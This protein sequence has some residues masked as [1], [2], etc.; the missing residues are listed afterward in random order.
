[1]KKGVFTVI[2]ICLCTLLA[3]QMPNT[4]NYQAVARNSSGQALA[5][6]AIKIR[7]SIIRGA[8]T[9][10]SETRNVTTNTLGLFNVQIG[11]SGATS[12]T[13]DFN[14]I[15]W[16]NNTP[17]ITLKVEL[18][19]N[20]SG[21]F[22]E[23]GNQTLASVPYAYAA[24]KAIDAVNLGGRYVDDAIA[25]N[26]GD[27]MRWS[28]ADNAWK[29]ATVTQPAV[30]TLQGII[31]SIA[32]SAQWVFLTT[33]GNNNLT[34]TITKPTTVVISGTATLG[35]NTT[36]QVANDVS[37]MPAFQ[38]I[39]NGVP[40]GTVTLFNPGNFPAAHIT[41]SKIVVPTATS[42]TIATPGT[43]RIGFAVRNNTTITLNNND[44]LSGYVMV[45]Q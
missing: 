40:A 3:A 45:L 19:V 5:S 14:S 6:Q 13:G 30:T 12:T 15:Y 24:K 39:E 42:G 26:D 22:T 33:N 27:V 21:V 9:L 18:D 11:G 44:W 23:M 8:T 17:A 7:L 32:P 20:N 43:Y 29:P 41:S 31:G 4:I 36:G 38:R 10:Y 1:M 34:I 25:P 37:F 35:H 2:S 28:A 16:L